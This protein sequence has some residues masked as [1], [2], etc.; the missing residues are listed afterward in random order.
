MGIMAMIFLVS[1]FEFLNG[2]L[3]NCIFQSQTNY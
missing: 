2:D 1:I 3:C